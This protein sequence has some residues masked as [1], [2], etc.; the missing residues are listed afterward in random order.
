MS[1]FHV[2]V[3]TSERKN[4]DWMKAVSRWS[5][6][7]GPII[8][9]ELKRETPV[10]KGTGAGRLRDSL[11]YTR[12]ITSQSAQ[13]QFKSRVPYLQYVIHGTQPHTIFPVATRAL[14][15]QSGGTDYFSKVVHSPGTKPNDFP[16]RTWNRLRERMVRS[17]KESV[18]VELEE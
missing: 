11:F 10:G 13:L 15:W 6:E 17:F 1:P 3:D 8:L 16:D 18:R 2:Q 7:N 9:E 4:F 5:D 14:H 12:Y